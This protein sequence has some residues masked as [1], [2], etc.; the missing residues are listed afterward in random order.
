MAAA[1]AL[2]DSLFVTQYYRPDL[3]GSGPFCGDLA[4][5]LAERGVRVEVLTSR[6]F[7]P[8]EAVL[9]DYR[10]GQR[11]SEILNGVRIERVP[12]WVPRGGSAAKRMLAE[13]LFLLRGLGALATGR[14]RRRRLVL[15]LCPSVLTVLLGVAAVRRGGCHVALVH[16]IQSG[17]ARGLGMV[18]GSRLAA[19]M[20]RVERT[21]LDRADLVVVLSEDMRRRLLAAGVRAPIRV[22]PIWVDPDLIHPL[23]R[24]PHERPTILYSGN[25]GRKQGLSQVIEL[26][27]LL[28]ARGSPLPIVIRGGGTQARALAEEIRARGLDNVT[29]APLLPPERLNEGLASGDI[30]LVPQD[31]NAADYAVPSKIFGIMAAGRPFVATARPG[32]TLWRLREES[33]AF[34]CVPPNDIGSLAETVLRLAED[35]ALRARLGASGRRYVV[36]HYSKRHVLERLLAAIAETGRLA[37]RPCGTS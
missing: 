15:S 11:D 21:V 4:E 20:S 5:W 1:Q 31:P 28:R 6:P 35:E 14:V 10:D 8:T 37:E 27:A 17:L 32:S 9:A 23:E 22:L 13:T 24:P 12:A 33:D 30:H 16:D 26:A 36:Q 19:L 25:L 2:A 34:L 3:I 18:G 7:Y 29:L